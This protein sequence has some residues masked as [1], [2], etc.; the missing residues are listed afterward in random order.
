MI[1][2]RGFIVVVIFSVCAVT[3][4]LMLGQP[5]AL[6]NFAARGVKSFFHVYCD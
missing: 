3:V 2:R 6:D 5:C 4:G 1:N